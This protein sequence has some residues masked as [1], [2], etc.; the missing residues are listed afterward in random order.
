[1]LQDLLEGFTVYRMWLALKL[2]VFFMIVASVWRLTLQVENEVSAA[3]SWT[4]TM[5]SSLR[6]L[7]LLDKG[8]QVASDSGM[9]NSL[10][11]FVHIQ[12]VL[13][14]FASAQQSLAGS[15]SSLWALTDL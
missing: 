14:G 3:V 10:S 8:R 9:L 13:D 7:F 15:A 11:S 1:M 2:I 12:G 6:A 4:S 5:A